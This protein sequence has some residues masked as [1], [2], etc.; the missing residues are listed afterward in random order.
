MWGL[1]KFIVYAIYVLMVQS[2]WCLPWNLTLKYFFSLIGSHEFLLILTLCTLSWQD[3]LSDE[4]RILSS[5]PYLI[6]NDQV[7]YLKSEVERYRGLADQ[8][9]VRSL[10][11]IFISLYHKVINKGGNGSWMRMFSSTHWASLFA[12]DF[13]FVLYNLCGSIIIPYTIAPDVPKFLT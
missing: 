8:L 10:W 7:H 6:L 2:R 4:Q 13:K 3:A 11:T 5:R 9:Q 12:N 1:M